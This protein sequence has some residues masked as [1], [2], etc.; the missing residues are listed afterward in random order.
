M[1]IEVF[2]PGCQRCETC[3]RNV[4][5]E[6]AELDLDCEIVHV[7]DISEFA[8]RGVWATP[9]IMVDGKI[10]SSGKVPSINELKRLLG[11]K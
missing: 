4:I 10:I 9:A 7:R 6:C 2:G 8:K 3:E 1:K 5:E 11:G